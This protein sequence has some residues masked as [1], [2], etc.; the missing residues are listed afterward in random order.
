MK[1][2]TRRRV[3][4]TA[5]LPV[6]LLLGQASDAFADG[7]LHKRKC[8]TCP[9]ATV[10][11]TIVEDVTAPTDAP[12]SEDAA[13]PEAPQTSDAFDQA[14]TGQ[15]DVA[16]ASDI[17]APNMLGDQFGSGQ[18]Q[19]SGIIV[20]PGNL[21]GRVGQIQFYPGVP[22]QFQGFVAVGNPAGINLVS[23]GIPTITV[24]P[25]P[26][27]I[28]PGD[29]NNIS[30]QSPG[31]TLPQ[32]TLG[33]VN[34]NISAILSNPLVAS[35]VN[36]VV[37]GIEQQL[38]GSGA[39]VLSV[40]SFGAQLTGDY[41]AEL[42]N[43][44]VQGDVIYQS[45][46]RQL[47]LL[48]VTNPS[49]GG[50]VGRT[51]IAD[52]NNPLPRDRFIFN[53]DYFNNVPLTANGWNV[54]RVSPGFEKTFFHQMTSIEVRF[55]FAST[56][57][58]NFT[59]GME[60]SNVEFGN[61]NVTLKGL[62]YASSRLNVAAGLGLSLPTADDVRVQLAN[63]QDLVRVNNDSVLLTPYAAALWTPNEKFFAQAWMQY[64]FD[65]NGNPVYLATANQGLAQVGRLTSQTLMQLDGQIGYWLYRSS[66]AQGL[67]LSALAPFLELHYNSTLND[68]DT[69]FSQGVLIGDL[70]G[71]TD[72]L[73]LSLGVTTLWGRNLATSLGLVVPLR[74]DY[75]RF[76]DYQIGTRA[77]YYFGATARDRRLSLRT[78]NF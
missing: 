21:A 61:I 48:N 78:S 42:G 4:W 20:S 65:T 64:S 55:P 2:Q 70:A 28:A 39:T 14:L 77:S 52:D 19:V 73:N 35:L 37:L 9:P 45:T 5:S 51:K 50:V 56:L 40:E 36:P 24:V 23:A 13:A 47:V 16:S 12:P 8:Q 6:A 60:S 59:Q 69:I 71:R 54:Q 58:S 17:I 1:T 18:G 38:A 3:L 46:I 66:C 22:G 7:F 63:G 33:L 34:A 68:A 76:F 75:D 27:G 10:S 43:A 25:L 29:L 53:Y 72:E 32:A 49:D 41:T 67:K 30:Y 62:L 57:D 74:D 15:Y 26:P 31:G 44:G 11:E